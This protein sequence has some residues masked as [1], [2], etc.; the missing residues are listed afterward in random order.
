M[1]AQHLARG[2]AAPGKW[3]EDENPADVH[4]RALIGLLELEECGVQRGQVLTHREDART[5]GC[6]VTTGENLSGGAACV[7]RAT[8]RVAPENHGG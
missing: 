7:I 8:P 1:P 3:I 6:G 5:V 2:H 4:V